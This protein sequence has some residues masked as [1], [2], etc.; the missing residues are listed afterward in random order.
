MK[1][2]REGGVF[3]VPLMGLRGLSPE[4]WGV[5]TVFDHREINKESPRREARL[6]TS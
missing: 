3:K 1:R 5:S 2:T 4:G 6:C